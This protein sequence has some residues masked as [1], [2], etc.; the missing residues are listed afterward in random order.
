MA[1]DFLGD[2]A[3]TEAGSGDG[4]EGAT[5]DFSGQRSMRCSG[6]IDVVGGKESKY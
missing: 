5:L 6:S 2:T 3:A 4:I 1:Y